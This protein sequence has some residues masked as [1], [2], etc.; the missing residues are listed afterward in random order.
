MAS[1]KGCISM[2]ILFFT[3]ILIY[4]STGGYD[5]ITEVIPIKRGES[6]MFKRIHGV[7]IGNK[8]KTLRVFVLLIFSI[9]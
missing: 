6:S 1:L 7:T 9:M 5:Y 3:Y 8:F 4:F 2:V